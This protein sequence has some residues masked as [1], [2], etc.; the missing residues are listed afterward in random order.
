M[1]QGK[2]ILA[3]ITA[4]AGSKGVVKKNIRPVM[5][6][7]L[8]AWTIDAAHS[9]KYIDRLVISTDGEE[10]MSVARTYGCEVPFVRPPEL[11]SDISASVDVVVHAIH[12]VGQGFDIILLLQPTSPLRTT[13]DIDNA[14]EQFANSGASSLISVNE[15][16]ESPCSFFSIENNALLPF[17]SSEKRPARRQDLPTYYVANG[18]IYILEINTFMSQKS[19]LFL[20][21]QAFVMPHSRSID[22]DTEQDFQYLEFILGLAS[23]EKLSG[24]VRNE[25]TK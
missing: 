16:E 6:K 12:M 5:G 21:T 10:I 14:I 2:K 9:S 22:L 13:A 17:I 4:R 15:A 1:I 23:Q 25:P 24:T 11:S 8:L 7:P 3:L 18:A 20:D 19:F